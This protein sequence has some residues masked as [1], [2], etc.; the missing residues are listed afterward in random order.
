MATLLLAAN[1]NPKIV[2]EHLG[3][4]SVI[5]TMDTYSHAMPGMHDVVTANMGQ[6]LQ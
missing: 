5:L 6:W 4:S 3:H 2:S 1:V